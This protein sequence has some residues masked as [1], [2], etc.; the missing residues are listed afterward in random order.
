MI[1]AARTNIA[2]QSI[3][4]GYLIIDDR[5]ADD[6]TIVLTEIVNWPSSPSSMLTV[7][8]IVLIYRNKSLSLYTH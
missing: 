4:T 7:L 6:Y 3:Y 8:Q 5:D 2:F 1:I